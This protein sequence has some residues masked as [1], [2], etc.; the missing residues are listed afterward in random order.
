MSNT[1]L[2]DTDYEAWLLE[3]IQPL[4]KLEDENWIADLKRDRSSR[5][6]DKT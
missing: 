2:Y 3:Q 1:Q 6:L 4:Q 5:N